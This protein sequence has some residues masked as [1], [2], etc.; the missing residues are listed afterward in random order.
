MNC[1][2]YETTYGRKVVKGI[3]KK[4]LDY[5]RRLYISWGTC[6]LIGLVIGIILGWI[7]SL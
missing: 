5:F 7:I 3:Y 1:S 2:K 4:K 6:I